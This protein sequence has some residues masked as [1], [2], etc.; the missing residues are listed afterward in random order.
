MTTTMRGGGKD[1]N[2]NRS[3]YRTNQNISIIS[4]FLASLLLTSFPLLE[5]T[6]G[7]LP[8]VGWPLDMLWGH[9]RL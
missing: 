2:K 9:L 8:T 4:V 3:S 6:L 1:K 5:V 7:Y